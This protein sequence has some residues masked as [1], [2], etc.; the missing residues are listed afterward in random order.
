MGRRS[1]WC[2][3]YGS[4]LRCADSDCEDAYVVLPAPVDEGLGGLVEVAI[5]E[6]DDG[7]GV[8]QVGLDG[9][10]CGECAGEVASSPLELSGVDSSDVLEC[11]VDVG[12]GGYDDHSL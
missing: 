11:E 1:L 12:G 4:A 2:V 10:Q 3:G 8:C 7:K 6:Q 9:V 5:R